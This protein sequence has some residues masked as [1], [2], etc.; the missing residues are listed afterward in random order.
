MTLNYGELKRGTSIELDGEPY[1]VVEYEHSKMQ[2]RAPVMKIRFRSLRTGKILDRT[3]QGDVK[4][5]LAHVD[6]RKAQYIY[7]DGDL[8]YFM[9]TESFEQFPMNE[10]QIKE[11]LKFLKDQIEL[12]LIFFEDNP[13]SLELPLNVDLKV[14]DSPPGVKGDTAQGASKLA[15]LE[16]GLQISVPLFVNEGDIVKVDTRTGE[17]LSRA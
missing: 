8:F 13:I 6:R 12:D 10:D 15:T 9:D 14:T 16:T 11:S 1:S 2:G 3:F 7:K 17:Y 4:F 5:S